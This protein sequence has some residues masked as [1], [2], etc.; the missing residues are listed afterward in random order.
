MSGGTS[1]CDVI[2][3]DANLGDF[4]ALSVTLDAGFFV[5]VAEL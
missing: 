2:T 4:L 3:F 5:D 1:A